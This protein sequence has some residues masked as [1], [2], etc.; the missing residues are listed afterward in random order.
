MTKTKT[1]ELNDKQALV[2]F[3]FLTKNEL[4]ERT[5]TTEE[6]DIET[7]SPNEYPELLKMLYGK[8]FYEL[9]TEAFPSPLIDD[10]K[11][12]CIFN[13]FVFEYPKNNGEDEKEVAKMLLETASTKEEQIILGKIL[14]QLIRAIK[15]IQA[16]NKTARISLKNIKSLN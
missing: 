11:A 3:V 2:V 7:L 13:A 5:S 15:Q 6:N 4:V 12:I 16:E 10:E 1:I 9:L 14:W 8:A